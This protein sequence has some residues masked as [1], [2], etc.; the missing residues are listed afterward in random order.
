MG[1]GPPLVWC[2]PLDSRCAP[3]WDSVRERRAWLVSQAQ[4]KDHHFRRCGLVAT[5]LPSL[6]R[7]PRKTHA[8]RSTTDGT[9]V[10]RLAF[11]I[12]PDVTIREGC[13]MSGSV[14][15]GSGA[16]TRAEA[17]AASTAMLSLGVAERSVRGRGLGTDAAGSAGRMLEPRVRT[18]ILEPMWRHDRRSRSRQPPTASPHSKSM[19]YVADRRHCA[20][21]ELHDR[22]RRLSSPGRNGSRSSTPP[23]KARPFRRSPIGGKPWC[24]TSVL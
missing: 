1:E 18:A 7:I 15:L 20:L 24:C 11:G 21:R 16:R 8:V 14:A 19:G 17:F 5:E 2:G 3:S 23:T 22:G 9:Y 13:L 6:W 10:S 12:N 4:R